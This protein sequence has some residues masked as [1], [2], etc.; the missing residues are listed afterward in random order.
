MAGPPAL[1]PAERGGA[2]RCDG[3]FSCRSVGNGAYPQGFG[4]CV[5]KRAER[6]WG[7]LECALLA[8]AALV[9]LFQGLCI[10]LPWWRA[11][12][13]DLPP[14]QSLLAYLDPDWIQ[15]CAWVT[16]S[17]CTLISSDQVES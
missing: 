10:F 4:L 9:L 8:L 14:A 5:E 17:F 7:C 6:A 12:L 1:K 11:L 13:G 16:D 2:G 15:G 3:S